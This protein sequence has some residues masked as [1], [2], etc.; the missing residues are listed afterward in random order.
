MKTGLVS[1]NLAAFYN[2]IFE[3]RQHSDYED[4]FR[5]EPH[6]VRPWLSQ[7][8]MF[9]REIAALAQGGAPGA[10]RGKGGEDA[11]AEA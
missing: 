4:F 3:C 11:S 8:E 5:V 9:I 10:T 6:V 7:A 1:K 2:E